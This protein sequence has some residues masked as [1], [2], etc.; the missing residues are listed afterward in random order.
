M[1]LA[2]DGQE[3]CRKYTTRARA[4]V[5]AMLPLA[6]A[7]FPQ[8][9]AARE[10]C[11]ISRVGRFAVRQERNLM[12]TTTLLTCA[13]LCAAACGVRADVEAKLTR[14]GH[15]TFGDTGLALSP[16][17]YAEGWHGT[18]LS[19]AERLSKFPNAKS[20]TAAWILK[21]SR[22][23]RL[24]HGTTRLVAAPDGRAAFRTEFVS[25]ADQKPEGVLLSM[26]LPA[27]RFGGLGWTAERKEGRV[28]AVLHA[29]QDQP[30]LRQGA[31]RRARAARRRHARLR[32]RRAH[33]RAPAGQPPLGRQLHPAHRLRTRT[34][35]ERRHARP[36][37]H[38][39]RVRAPARRLRGAHAHPPRRRL[40]AARLQEGRPRRLRA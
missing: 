1:P 35:R 13:A 38:R 21:G 33:D 4:I 3:T 22:D 27:S 17:V 7:G 30:V 26:N 6:A 11:I 9:A 8:L 29:R 32:V 25:D 20:G 5:T 23:A 34:V 16:T 2:E 39:R 28:P 10:S 36:H 18:A 19:R 37:R 24:G 31:P 14:D 12:R 40:G 15:V